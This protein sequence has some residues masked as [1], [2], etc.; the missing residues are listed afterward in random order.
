[1]PSEIAA[2]PRQTPPPS[3]VLQAT[4]PLDRRTPYK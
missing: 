4:T 1:M 3:F 2:P